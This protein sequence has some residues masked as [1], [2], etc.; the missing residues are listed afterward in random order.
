MMQQQNPNAPGAQMV[1]AAGQWLEFTERHP[2]EN[3][4]NHFQE[5]Y[6]GHFLHQHPEFIKVLFDKLQQH[7]DISRAE[8]NVKYGYN[9]IAQMDVRDRLTAAGADSAKIQELGKIQAALTEEA[10]LGTVGIGP[11]GHHLR[12]TSKMDISSEHFLSLLMG[13]LHEVHQHNHQVMVDHGHG[14]HLPNPQ[15]PNNPTTISPLGVNRP[16]YDSN[17]Q[18]QGHNFQPGYY[19]GQAGY[20]QAPPPGVEAHHGPSGKTG[21]ALGALKLLTGV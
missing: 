4:K 9:K 13:S 12:A 1:Q 17:G 14:H 18:F 3:M 2:P 20:P 5:D 21:L 8:Y 19:Y 15:D 6:V 10:N 16:Q 7:G 11:D